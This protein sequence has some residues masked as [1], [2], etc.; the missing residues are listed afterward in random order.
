[1]KSEKAKQFLEAATGF[2]VG[3]MP[4]VFIV[5]YDEAIKA[6][7]LAEAEMRERAIGHTENYVNIIM[8]MVVVSANPAMMYARTWTTSLKFSTTLK[9]NKL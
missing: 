8:N 9:P 5:T 1:M 7:E 4:D 3:E 6:V 2:A